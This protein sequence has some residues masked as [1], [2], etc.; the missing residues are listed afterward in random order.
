VLSVCGGKW[1]NST[2]VRRLKKDRCDVAES[3]HSEELKD[4]W[5]KVKTKEART[6]RASDGFDSAGLRNVP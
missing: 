5:E 4:G 1:T 6:S 3:S 2:P